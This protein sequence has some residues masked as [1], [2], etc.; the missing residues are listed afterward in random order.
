MEL[1]VGVGITVIV[2]VSVTE[3]QGPGGS[4]VVNV[5]TI[6]PIKPS[7]GVYVL[8]KLL[9]LENVPPFE[10]V[11]LPDEAAPPTIPFNC[12]VPFRQ[13]GL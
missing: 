8:V 11:Q 3:L 2:T 5:K 4:F 1:I 13:T 12:N 10:D 7:G 6:V 9:A